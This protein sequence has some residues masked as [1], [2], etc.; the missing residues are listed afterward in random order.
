VLDEDRVN[1]LVDTVWRFEDVDNVR[2][3]TRL[4]E[5]RSAGR[6]DNGVK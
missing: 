4:V 3:L 1:Q 5:R 6:G 2:E